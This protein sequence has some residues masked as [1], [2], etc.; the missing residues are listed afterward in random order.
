MWL[1]ELRQQLRQ[2]PV[3]EIAPYQRLR[4][5]ISIKTGFFSMNGLASDVAF[6]VFTPCEAFTG[7]CAALSCS[8]VPFHLKCMYTQ[9]KGHLHYEV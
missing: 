5:N 9:H 8:R 2:G 3:N 4:N 6:S 1:E 7:S